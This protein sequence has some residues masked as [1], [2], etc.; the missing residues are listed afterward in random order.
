MIDSQEQQAL[1]E[2]TRRHF[3]RNC[4]VGLGGMALGTMLSGGRDPAVGRDPAA[5]VQYGQPRTARRCRRPKSVIFMF[6]AGGPSQLELFDPKPKLQELSGQVIPESYVKG[7]RFAFIKAD[8]KLLGTVRKF[9]RTWAVGRSHQR[10][11]APSGG[12]RR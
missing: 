10:V 6:M 5:R 12:G 11:S 7:K 3:F 2:L 9:E 1:R 8:A 4:Q